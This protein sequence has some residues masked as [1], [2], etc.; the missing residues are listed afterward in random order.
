MVATRKLVGESAVQPAAQTMDL[1]AALESK[2][3]VLA[4]EWR[5]RYYC[6][7]SSLTTVAQL[8]GV[9]EPLIAE[10]GRSLPASL[11]L[12]AAAWGR[13]QGLLRLSH[14]RGEEGLHEEFFLLRAVLEQAANALFAP[15]V[16]RKRLRMMLDAAQAQAVAMFSRLQSPADE[17]LPPQARFGGVVV[18][19][20]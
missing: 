20:V 16:E 18:E 11:D 13:T 17:L 12:P 2:A 1:A 8:D 9:V 15:L 14:S 19:T 5:K 10:L 7:D 3:A 6:T 4:A